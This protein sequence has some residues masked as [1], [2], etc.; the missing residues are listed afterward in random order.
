MLRHPRC[1]VSALLAAQARKRALEVSLTRLPLQAQL[2]LQ[3][4]EMAAQAELAQ[5]KSWQAGQVVLRRHSGWPEGAKQL[6]VVLTVARGFPTAG[7]WDCHHPRQLAAKVAMP[8]A[9]AVA[10]A[11]AAAVAAGG[12]CQRMTPTL[13]THLQHPDTLACHHRQRLLHLCPQ[14]LLLRHALQHSL[15]P[16]ASAQHAHQP[17]T[18]F[19]EPNPHPSC[20]LWLTPRLPLAEKH[21]LVPAVHHRHLVPPWPRQPPSSAPVATVSRAQPH[22]SVRA[23]A[24]TLFRQWLHVCAPPLWPQAAQP[25]PAQASLCMASETAKHCCSVRLLLPATVRVPWRECHLRPERHLWTLALASWGAA[26]SACTCAGSGRA[27]AAG[28]PQVQDL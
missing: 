8:A 2:Q 26:R 1:S 16:A 18:H 5:G 10:A 6:L 17:Q 7:T 15:Q 11:A 20:G 28:S 14:V 23:G 4:L 3:I 22:R 25:A 19:A 24:L 21:Q 9:A 27:T 12:A 13:E